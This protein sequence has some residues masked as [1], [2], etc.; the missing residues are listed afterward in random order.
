MCQTATMPRLLNTVGEQRW[1]SAKLP[2]ILGSFASANCAIDDHVCPS[3]YLL[4]WE[5][6]RRPSLATLT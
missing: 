3:Y 6:C 2:M 4:S 5:F 1:A